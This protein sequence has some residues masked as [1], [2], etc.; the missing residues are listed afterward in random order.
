MP[1][2]GRGRSPSIDC[3]RSYPYPS[4]SRNVELHKPMNLLGSV[5][6][7]KEWDDTR[8]P[9]CMEPPHNAVLLKCSSHENGCRPYMCNTSYRHSNCLDQFCKSFSSHLSSALLEQIPF[10]NTASSPT[11]E[12][13]P[14][15][16]TVSNDREVRSQPEPP[17]Q[18]GSFLPS[19]PRFE[20]GSDLQPK[21]ICP[22]CR[23]EIHG[24]KVWEPARR[25]MNLKPR[26]CSLET[27]EFQGTYPELRKH[28]R[29][30][31][32]SVR[33]T[34]V[35]PSQQHD[36]LRM[37]HERDLNDL[38]SSIGASS[39]TEYQRDDI[40][41]PGSVA[42]FMAMFYEI[43]SSIDDVNQMV[44]SLSN[45]RPRTPLHDRR[46]GTINRVSNVTQTNQSAR[47]R[48]NLPSVHQPERIH[49]GRWGSNLSSFHNGEANRTARWRT[50]LPTSSRMP[51]D[52]HQHYRE[53]SPGFRTPSMRHPRDPR[54]TRNNPRSNISSSRRISG[55]Q[56]RWRDQRWSTYNNQ[57]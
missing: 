51:R 47:W 8:C 16:S 5:D 20:Y 36:W 19:E 11:L 54:F 45:L 40:N 29:L 37:E 24:Y 53:L 9:I 17:D 39:S 21:L 28:A 48:S 2:V 22:L 49:R 12:E 10:T 56:L 34:E 23:G 44:S 42:D 52:V 33:P 18:Y 46:S 1:K 6:E 25:Y 3:S 57:Q 43:L 31:H 27:C 4:S 13:I 55:H 7:M 30:E 32:P 15:S 26:G 41:Q 50:N 35:D 14:V 38:F